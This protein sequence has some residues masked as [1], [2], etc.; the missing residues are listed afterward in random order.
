MENTIMTIDELCGFAWETAIKNVA[1]VLN[2]AFCMNYSFADWAMIEKLVHTMKNIKF[3][4]N[5]DIIK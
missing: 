4:V 1:D 3:D 5:G 2:N